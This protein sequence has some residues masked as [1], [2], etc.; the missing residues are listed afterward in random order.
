MT[1]L[2]AALF[3]VGLIGG[4]FLFAGCAERSALVEPVGTDFSIRESLALP[5]GW[6]TPPI[7]AVIDTNSDAVVAAWRSEDAFRH[8]AAFG[9]FDGDGLPD[10]ARILFN[11]QGD[12]AAFF[13]SRST[14]E[15]DVVVQQEI[16]AGPLSVIDQFGLTTVAVGEHPTACGKGY[17]PCAPDEPA[18]LEIATDAIKLI[19][20]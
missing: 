7:G 14:G 11:D 4:S 10:A 15:G 16:F 17:W 12:R 8:L 5:D 19:L 20:F 2:P 6:R 3:A 1:D 13:I 9:E 18:M